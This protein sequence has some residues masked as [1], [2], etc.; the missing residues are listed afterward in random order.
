MKKNLTVLL[1]FCFFI[2]V[3]AQQIPVNSSGLQ[4]S[5]NFYDRHIYYPGDG[6]SEPILVRVSITNSGASTLRFKMAD[7]HSFSLD[8]SVI[9]TKN[10]FVKHS[11][12]WLRKQ[13]SNRKIYFREV[14]L[15]PGET[16]SF[17]ENLKDYIHL[18][19]PG[20][21]IL[22]SNFFPE[23]KHSPDA[24]DFHNTSNRLSFEVKPAPGPAGLGSIPV[25]ENTGE[26]LEAQMIPPDQV[27]TYILAARQKSRWEQFFLYLDIERMIERNPARNK[28]YKAESEMGRYRMIEN[29]RHELRQARIEKD[30][31][32]IPVDFEIERTTYTGTEAEVRVIE[33]FAYKDFRE[34]KRFTYYLSSRDGIWTVYDYVVEN[35]G[36]E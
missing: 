5:I 31:V 24:S 25:S 28:Q 32:A 2:T 33:W 19:L 7:E 4:F 11:R 29:F 30:I 18:E 22:Q 23:L 10:R 36:T 21:Y 26:V 3:F 8:F 20:V 9:D 13:N 14:S 16:Y 12:D 17:I 27:I 34:K 35:L 6:N 15:E 1:V